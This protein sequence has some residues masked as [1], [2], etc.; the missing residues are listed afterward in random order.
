MSE[1]KLLKVGPEIFVGNEE[2]GS[3]TGCYVVRYQMTPQG[4]QVG[5]MPAFA[6][7]SD[8]AITLEKNQVIAAI[9]APEDMVGAYIQTT[10]G[11]Q[12]APAGSVPN[13]KLV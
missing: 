2:E 12:V 1:L 10:T 3:F 13:L 8:K 4:M 11:I 9:D 5:I 6:P 7:F